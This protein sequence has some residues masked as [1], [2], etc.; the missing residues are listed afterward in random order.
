MPAL[1]KAA[2]MNGEPKV[3]KK[4][5]RRQ[6]FSVRDEPE[7]R[8]GGLRRHNGPDDARAVTIVL[9]VV[10]LAHGAGDRW[11]GRIEGD[12]PLDAAGPNAAFPGTE[13]SLE[14]RVVVAIGGSHVEVLAGADDPDRDVR[15]E[16][17]VRPSGCDLEL[18]RQA[19]AGQLVG[20]PGG[21][22]GRSVGGARYSAS[23]TSSPHSLSGPSAGASQRARCGMNRSGAAPC[24]CHSPGGVWIVS[25]GRISMTS[26]PRA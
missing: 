24:Q 4:V 9:R 20:G 23:L 13:R 26:P 25:P 14:P 12:V 11:L 5:W 7:R 19:N 22:R 17:A 18:G 10:C 2:S 8:P 6:L 3:N 15:P 16:A 1:S 21:H